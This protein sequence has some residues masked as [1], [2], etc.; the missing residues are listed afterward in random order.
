LSDIKS[1]AIS[2]II[3]KWLANMTKN[4]TLPLHKVAR[5]SL[6][7]IVRIPDGNSKAQLI[8]LGVHVGVLVRCLER[9]PGGTLVIEKNRQEIA[10]GMNLASTILVS[11]VRHD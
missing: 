5:G 2:R 4:E 8:R 7:R 11:P 9:L 6:V 1:D 3:R 10:L